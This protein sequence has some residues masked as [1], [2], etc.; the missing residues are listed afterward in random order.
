[1]EKYR[2]TDR[3]E[4]ILQH[5]SDNFMQGSIETKMIGNDVVKVTEQAGENRYF[6]IDSDGSITESDTLSME[7]LHQ[8]M[9]EYVFE[10]MDSVYQPQVEHDRQT[11]VISAYGGP[12]S[13]KTVACMDICQQLKKRGYNAEYVSEVAKDYVYD[14]NYDMLDGTPEHQYE[15]LQEQLKRV[16]R[17]MGKVD[18]VVTDSPVLLNGIY[19]QQLTPEYEQMLLRLHEQYNNFVFVVNR[20]AGHFQEEGR[21]HDLEESMEKDAQIRD[22]LD[23]HQIYYGTYEH[24]TVGKIVDNSIHTLNRI[25][26]EHDYSLLREFISE[27]YY[28][29]AIEI[30]VASD[31]M[32]QL[33][34]QTGDSITVGIEAGQVKLPEGYEPTS[35][36]QNLQQSH[37]IHPDT[38]KMTQVLGQFETDCQVPEH[39][40]LTCQ[41][42]N[43]S[44][45]ELVPGE[46][47]EEIIHRYC[48]QDLMKHDLWNMK[49]WERK[50]VPAAHPSLEGYTWN[51]FG[52]GYGCLLNPEQEAVARYGNYP[53]MEGDMKGWNDEVQKFMRGAEAKEAESIQEQKQEGTLTKGQSPSFFQEEEL[54]SEEELMLLEAQAEQ[55]MVMER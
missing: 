52:S 51:H 40:R 36:I 27:H 54:I 32:F 26:Q 42:A 4:K 22:M 53:K 43:G 8:D 6:S 19:N 47:E 11:L 29:D 14:E 31:R 12:G 2:I 21:I 38:E 28:K 45:Y 13:G 35:G 23:E 17:Y 25:R 20:D 3:Q 16:D 34:D 18:F 55:G 1:M 44:S 39:L 41:S 48:Q 50:G 7:E 5:L 24:R 49:F 33:K 10:H 37:F 30:E 46:T 15:M 9:N